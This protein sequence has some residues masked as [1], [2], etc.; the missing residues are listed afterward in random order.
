M[1]RL[2]HTVVELLKLATDEKRAESIR[3]NSESI[4]PQLLAQFMER[5]TRPREKQ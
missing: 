1:L 3:R 2:E 4:S 5:Q